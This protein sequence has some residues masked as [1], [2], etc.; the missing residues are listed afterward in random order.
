MGFRLLRQ[1]VSINSLL[2]VTNEIRLQSPVLES[3]Y[4]L[5]IC[6]MRLSVLQSQQKSLNACLHVKIG[7]T[8]P[9]RLE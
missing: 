3:K 7:V 9:T 6:Q 1:M 4:S 5:E 8:P 2:L